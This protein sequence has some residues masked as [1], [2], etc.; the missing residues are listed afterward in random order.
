MCPFEKLVMVR[1]E[2]SFGAAE[3]CTIPSGGGSDA[4]S[5]EEPGPT[6]S[7][8]RLAAGEQSKEVGGLLVSRLL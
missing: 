6:P 3:S 7:E 4:A 1:N 8:A 2:F 5:H